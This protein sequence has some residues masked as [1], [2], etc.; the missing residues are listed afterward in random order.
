MAQKREAFRLQP[1][2]SLQRPTPRWRKQGSNPRSLHDG[3]DGFRS[4]LR[5]GAFGIE[6]AVRIHLARPQ[7]LPLPVRPKDSWQMLPLIGEAV[8]KRGQ[9]GAWVAFNLTSPLTRS[10]R[11]R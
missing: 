7:N 4:T 5:L 1:P 11:S 2:S 9:R 3:D 8:A 10:R 6:A